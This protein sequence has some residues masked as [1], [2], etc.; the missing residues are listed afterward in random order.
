MCAWCSA[1]ASRA[2][3]RN[4]FT[5]FWSR[6]R[7]TRILLITTWRSKPSMP[8]AL[9][10][11]SSAI[12][13]S[14]RCL[15][16][17][18]R[19]RVSATSSRCYVLGRGLRNRGPV[20]ACVGRMRLALVLVLA[21]CQSRSEADPRRDPRCVQVD[22]GY[23]RTSE[24]PLVADVVAS[25]LEVPWGLAFLPDGSMLVSERAGRLVRIADGAKRELAH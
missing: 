16:I 14:A 9:A 6:A 2:S 21:A 19:P 4:I 3:S 1:A 7:S 22:Y 5:T 24:V 13:P 11:S 8:P 25:G 15:M 18:Y 12:P 17:W 10:S 23:G 20:Y